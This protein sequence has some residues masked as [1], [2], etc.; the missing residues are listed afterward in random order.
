[1]E[2]VGQL[3]VF[4]ARLHQGI[5]REEFSICNHKRKKDRGDPGTEF[6]EKAIG[7]DP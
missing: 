1:M 5:L 3:Y 2:K 4:K 6:L 7:T